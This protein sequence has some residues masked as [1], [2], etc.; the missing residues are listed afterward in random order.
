MSKVTQQ[1][2]AE[3]GLNQ[4]GDSRACAVPP[5]ALPPPKP[6]K[7]M[8]RSA[9]EL[10]PPDPHTRDW[11]ENLP[12]QVK[13]GCRSTRNQK[14]MSQAWPERLSVSGMRMTVTRI[15]SAKR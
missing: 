13:S 6:Q 10:G 5:L 3:L 14:P 8:R 7:G 12:L 1:E 9:R 15:A 4:G 2:V 11:E